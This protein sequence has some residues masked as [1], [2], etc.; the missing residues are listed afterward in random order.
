MHRSWLLER[1]K[2]LIL[3]WC[4]FGSGSDWVIVQ[5]CLTVCLS[6]LNDFHSVKWR[7]LRSGI[8]RG[9]SVSSCMFML[10]AR[11]QYFYVV[12]EQFNSMYI[13]SFDCWF[14]RFT[15]Q[16][17]VAAPMLVFLSEMKRGPLTS[18]VRANSNNGCMHK[19]VK[20]TLHTSWTSPVAKCLQPTTGAQIARA[21]C[22]R[23]GPEDLWSL[24]LIFTVYLNSLCPNLSCLSEF[25]LPCCHFLHFYF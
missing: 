20:Y 11:I 2:Q 10:V 5:F 18:L 1:T 7:S 25:L 24:S 4:Q 22:G 9:K 3:N 6:E 16:C 13:H 19:M 8:R 21:Q 23:H 17:V 12:H 15:S 14:Y